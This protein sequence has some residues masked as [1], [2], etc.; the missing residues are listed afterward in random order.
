MTQH[1]TEAATHKN[2]HKRKKAAVIYTMYSNA[3]LNHKNGLNK[4]EKPKYQRER[5][6]GVEN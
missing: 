5:E 1:Q 3:S 6:I 2:M 4:K